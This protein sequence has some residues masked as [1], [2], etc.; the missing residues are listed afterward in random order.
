MCTHA[1]ADAHAVYAHAVRTLSTRTP[2]GTYAH[3]E[4]KYRTAR[5]YARRSPYACRTRRPYA[6]CTHA[7]L[8]PYAA[9]RNH[10]TSQKWPA[11][12][13]CRGLQ[14]KKQSVCMAISDFVGPGQGPGPVLAL[15]DIV[16]ACRRRPL[17]CS[18]LVL[19]CLAEVKL[20]D[21]N[22]FA[23]PPSESPQ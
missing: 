3:A 20:G 16:V 8:T 4:I 2:S 18:T 11:L 14:I 7:V 15:A 17:G 10:A 23:N 12:C 5:R 19:G 1:H 22:L 13:A 21:T 9:N 6:R